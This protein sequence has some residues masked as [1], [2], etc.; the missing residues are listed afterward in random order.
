M[1]MKVDVV[2]SG[3]GVEG[4]LVMVLAA[5]NL[6]DTNL[7]SSTTTALPMSMLPAHC[8]SDSTIHQIREFYLP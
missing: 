2:K 4:G 7:I 3:E 6:H 1:K 8:Q 5:L